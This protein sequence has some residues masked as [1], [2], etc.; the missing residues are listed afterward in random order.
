MIGKNID[1]AYIQEIKKAQINPDLCIKY[2]KDVKIIYTPLH[3]TGNKPVRRILKEI[4]FENVYVVP[5]Q[6]HPDPEFSTV[7][8]PNPEEKSVFE[9]AI[10]MA[11]KEEV[12]L[13]I[14][15]DPDADRMWVVKD[16][17]RIYYPYR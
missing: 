8:Y 7:D 5:E 14:G 17:S 4:G 10:N 11:K 6:E 16:D 13:I 1:D 3:G 2:G 9:I 15:T 12:D